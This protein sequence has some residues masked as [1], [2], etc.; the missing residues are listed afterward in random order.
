MNT[1][2]EEEQ[3]Q[4]VLLNGVKKIYTQFSEVSSREESVNFRSSFH[5]YRE[6][7]FA[8]SGTC[9]YMLNN[10]VY[11][12]EPG[13]CV[14]IDKWIHHSF[15]YTENDKHLLHLWGHVHPGNMALRLIRVHLNGQHHPDG[16]IIHVN[17]D[18]HS[19]FTRR[20]DMLN[21]LPQSPSE[22]QIRLYLSSPINA[23]LEEFYL[24]RFVN[25][26]PAAGDDLINSVK[27]Y[28]RSRNGVGCSLEQLAKIS[29]YSRCYLAHRFQKSTGISIGKY[30]NKIRMEFTICARQRGLK[31]K[32]IAFELGFSSPNNF[33][34]W[35]NKQSD[36]NMVI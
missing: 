17:N 32:E 25:S 30:I 35:L 12:L 13:S 8:I 16:K 27:L 36:K 26:L 10:N 34:N 18:L 9:R 4:Q 7:L 24:H 11:D 23:L 29:G 14:F 28:I 2:N 19:F 31:S 6:F 33:W 5:P 22:E 15:C 20:C 21:A 3:I 1:R